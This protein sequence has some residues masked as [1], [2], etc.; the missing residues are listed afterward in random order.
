MK[1]RLLIAFCSSAELKRR[2]DMRVRYPIVKFLWSLP[3]YVL[4][5]AEYD[6]SSE[7]E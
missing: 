1:R 7:P 5:V 4:D 6:P 3:Y 2:L